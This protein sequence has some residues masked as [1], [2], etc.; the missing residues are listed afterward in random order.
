MKRGEGE[1]KE[2]ARIGEEKGKDKGRI[3]EG[4]G[5]SGRIGEG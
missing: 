2:R 3:G 4:Y 5:E 1:G